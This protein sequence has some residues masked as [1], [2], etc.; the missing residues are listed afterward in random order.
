MKVSTLKTTLHFRTEKGNKVNIKPCVRFALALFV[1]A[2]FF[3]LKSILA[4]AL[5]VVIHECA[6]F[7][8]CAKY[9]IKVFAMTPLPWGM[10]VAT[11]LIYNKR[12]QV[13]VS[14]AGPLSNFAVLLI[15]VF[16]KK[17]MNINSDFFELFVIA[18]FADGFL[19]LLPVLPLDGGIILKANLCEK[20]GLAAGFAKCIYISAFSGAIILVLGAMIILATGYNFSYFAAGLFIIANLKHERELLLCIKKRIFTGEIKS[21][22]KIRYINVDASCHA[23]CLAN[24]ISAAYTIVFL[25]S[26][27]GKFIGEASQELLIKK[28]FENTLIT[29]GECVEKN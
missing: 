21:M 10:T 28:L 14:V 11:P 13:R 12:L 29:V 18:N 7:A 5:A 9:R 27:D 2:L 16:I 6:H 15:C 24:L 23:L 1:W 25:V 19:N 17:V 3:S 26:R 20:F 8:V 22:P 4:V